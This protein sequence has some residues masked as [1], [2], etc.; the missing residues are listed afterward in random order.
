MKALRLVLVVVAVGAW[1]ILGVAL[2]A[3]VDGPQT[4]TLAGIIA[5]GVAL[6]IPCW[7]A[8]GINRV[9]A[10]CRNGAPRRPW[11]FWAYLTF[12]LGLWLNAWHMLGSLFAAG[13]GL[14]F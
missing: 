11:D 3:A 9:Y 12:A 4:G 7:L 14:Q 13:G 1:V 2:V 5:L 10:F 6:G 8:F